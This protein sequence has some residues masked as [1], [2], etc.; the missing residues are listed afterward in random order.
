MKSGCCI[1]IVEIENG[2]NLR[3][4]S[5]ERIQIL[6]LGSML[7]SFKQ[8]SDNHF[9]FFSFLFLHYHSHLF[10]KEYPELFRQGCV[11]LKT[12]QNK[13]MHECLN[14][15]KSEDKPN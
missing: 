15:Q 1:L 2:E 10:P 14:F 7:H 13:K 8:N 6:Y 5:M 12:G 3:K 9:T 4:F 11:I